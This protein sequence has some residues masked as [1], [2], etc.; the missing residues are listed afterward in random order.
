MVLKSKKEKVALMETRVEKWSP[1]A[2][3]QGK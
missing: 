3:R 2:G 1:G